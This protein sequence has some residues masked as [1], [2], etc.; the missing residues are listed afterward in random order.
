[1]SEARSAIDGAA[2]V[3]CGA[4]CETDGFP[5][6]IDGARRIALGARRAIDGA[7]DTMRR[8]SQLLSESADN[9]LTT[10]QRNKDDRTTTWRAPLDAPSTRCNLRRDVLDQ[11]AVRAT[12]VF[13]TAEERVSRNLERRTKHLTE[14][15]PD[16]FCGIEVH[17]LELR[18]HFEFR[19]NN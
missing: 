10:Y 9:R 11:G 8:A 7:A 5:S 1:M 2:S 12:R 14:L 6:A 13:L 19:R 18:S 4:Q 3:R 15:R 17:V 16:V